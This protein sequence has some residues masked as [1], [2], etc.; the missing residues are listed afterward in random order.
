MKSKKY[1]IVVSIIIIAV[2]AIV[3]TILNFHLYPNFIKQWLGACLPTDDLR[4]YCMAISSGALTSALVTLLISC[5]EYDVEKQKALE[6]FC[7]ANIRY[8]S[9]LY[10][11]E[12]LRIGIPVEM[13]EEYYSDISQLSLSEN[14]GH[15]YESEKKIKEYIWAHE[16]DAVKELCATPS[17][18]MVYLKEDFDKRIEEYDKQID[19]IMKQYIA[20]SENMDK[21]ELTATISRI[22]FLFG[23]KKYRKN[24]LHAEIYMKQLELMSKIQNVS[25]HFREYYKAENGNKPV[26]IHFIMEIQNYLFSTERKNDFYIVHM[27]YLYDMYCNIHKLLKFIYG[28]KKYI[29]PEPKIE[30]FTKCN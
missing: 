4:N 11:L 25:F 7:D 27:Q 10:N 28:N 6:D 13:L 12:Y 17:A 21:H 24:F 18:K 22:D 26:M 20:L 8:I 16:S 2:S 29:E 3:F 15:E 23:N 9:A 19:T 30:N 1:S 14:M 5:S